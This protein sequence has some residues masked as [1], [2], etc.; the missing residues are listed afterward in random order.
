MIYLYLYLIIALYI[1][2]AY[3]YLFHVYFMPSKVK[4]G[5]KL[6]KI[7]VY[8]LLFISIFAIAPYG[9]YEIIKEFKNGGFTK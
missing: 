7:R 4:N 3:V 5:S 8:G 6:E 9:L 1:A 2:L